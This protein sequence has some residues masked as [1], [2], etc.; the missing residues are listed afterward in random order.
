M[1]EDD[2]GKRITTLYDCYDTHTLFS[3]QINSKLAS[4]LPKRGLA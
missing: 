3:P 2:Q 1:N 4:L